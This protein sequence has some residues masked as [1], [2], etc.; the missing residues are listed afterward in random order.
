MK[1]ICTIESNSTYPREYETETRNARLLAAAYGRA[2]G[3]ETITVTTKSGK[4]LSRMIWS[5]EKRKYIYV[6]F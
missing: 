2:E 5:V 1:Y 6:S 3:G 4:V